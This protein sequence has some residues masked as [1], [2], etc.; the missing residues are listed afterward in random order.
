[1]PFMIHARALFS[2][3]LGVLEVVGATPHGDGVSR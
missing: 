3:R 2:V 1:M